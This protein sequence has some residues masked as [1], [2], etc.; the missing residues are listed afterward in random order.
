MAGAEEPAIAHESVSRTLV[1]T[2]STTS[3]GRSARSVVAANRATSTTRSGTVAG[4]ALAG[5]IRGVLM[6]APSLSA[7]IYNI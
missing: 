6:R 2:A 3:A 1:L 7:A 4:L 5:T